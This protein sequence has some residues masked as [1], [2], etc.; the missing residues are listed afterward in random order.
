MTYFVGTQ[1]AM[2]YTK[3][4]DWR[5]VN[6]SWRGVWRSL[7]SVSHFEVKTPTSHVRKRYMRPSRV[8]NPGNAGLPRSIAGSVLTGDHNCENR[9]APKDEYRP[10]ISLVDSQCKERS[11]SIDESIIVVMPSSI[12]KGIRFP[13][14]RKSI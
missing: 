10:G 1:T 11:R 2:L 12:I 8:E 5:L 14:Y 9:D 3:P 13:H 4:Q 7:R 6:T